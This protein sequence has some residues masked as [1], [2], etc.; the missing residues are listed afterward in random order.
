MAI[1]YSDRE[2]SI[3]SIKLRIIIKL[4]EK[5]VM[6]SIVNTFGLYIHYVIN[7]RS[8]VQLGRTCHEARIVYGQFYHNDTTKLQFK[9]RNTLH[10]KRYVSLTDYD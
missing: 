8:K 6:Q 7:V 5:Q 9:L 2:S 10:G 4:Y 1:L 3:G